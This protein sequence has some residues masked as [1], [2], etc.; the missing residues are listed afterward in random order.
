MAVAVYAL[1]SLGCCIWIC[2]YL[3]LGGNLSSLQLSDRSN[4]SFDFSVPP[5]FS[6]EDGSDNFQDPYILKLNNKS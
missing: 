4:K 1:K 6:C 3:G 2:P 5:T